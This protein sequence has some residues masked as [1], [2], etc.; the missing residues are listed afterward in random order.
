MLFVIAI[1]NISFLLSFFI[2]G[3]MI[4]RTSMR[5]YYI[6]RTFSLPFLSNSISDSLNAYQGLYSKSFR[7]CSL[8]LFAR[9][10]LARH[11]DIESEN[12]CDS[13]DIIFA[14]ALKSL[15]STLS[16]SSRTLSNKDGATMIIKFT[17]QMNF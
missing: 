5:F 13:E 6:R 12:G 1:L 9:K 3:L 2:N 8:A 4:T 17:M 15:Q 16:N 10:K 14:D 7:S 11:V